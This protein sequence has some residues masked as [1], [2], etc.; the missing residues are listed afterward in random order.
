MFNFIPFRFG[1]TPFSTESD[2]GNEKRVPGS[3][4][5]FLGVANKQSIVIATHNHYTKL[6]VDSVQNVLRQPNIAIR[7]SAIYS[8]SVEQFGWHVVEG[9]ASVFSLHLMN[10]LASLTDENG[11]IYV[12]ITS[13]SYP[14]RC[15]HACLN[16]AQQLV[17][18]ITIIFYLSCFDITVC[19]T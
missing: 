3:N 9:I 1:Y 17:C 8:F 16:E 18:N 4:V 19:C 6:D 11:Y 2:H 5:K 10:I 12:L 15:A 14:Q 13:I 7:Q